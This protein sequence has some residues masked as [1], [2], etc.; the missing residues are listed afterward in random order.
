M[1]AKQTL[2]F[3]ILALTALFAAGCVP[4]IIILYSYKPLYTAGSWAGALI[5]LGLAGVLW[6]ARKR[7]ISETVLAAVYLGS[8][9]GLLWVIEIGINNVFTPPVAQRDP[10]DNIFWAVIAIMILVYSGL[11]TFQSERMRAGLLTGTVS[12]TISGLLACWA[13]LFLIVF[14]MPL[15]LRDPANIQEWSARADYLPSA[16][17]AEYFAYET[18]LGAFMH[19]GLLGTVMGFLLGVLGGLGG[20]VIRWLVPRQ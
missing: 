5:L 11:R 12:G 8:A 16:S 17:M 3:S 19:L 2:T 9:A 7:E 4:V 6:W 18:L 13:G 14:G 20:R 15:L 10:L 1:R